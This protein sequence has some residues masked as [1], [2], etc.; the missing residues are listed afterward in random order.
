[1]CAQVNSPLEGPLLSELASRVVESGVVDPDGLNRLKLEFCR[2]HG[3]SWMPRNSDIISALPPG[4]VEKFGPKLRLKKVR[5]ISGVNV[6]GVMSS[7]WLSAW[8]LRLLPNGERVPDEL[9]LRGT[10][11][12]E[13][14]AIGIR[15][16][17]TDHQPP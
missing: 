11:R 5:S 14:H 12:D 2:Q 16:I 3:L 17:L 8:P 13:G 7:P 9:H 4:M 10:R 15:S 1:M 6:I